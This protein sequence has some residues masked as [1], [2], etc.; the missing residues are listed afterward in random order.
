LKFAV[1]PPPKASPTYKA[2]SQVSLIDSQSLALQQ[3]LD[4]DLEQ[5]AALNRAKVRRQRLTVGVGGGL[6]AAAVAVTLLLVLPTGK[7]TNVCQIPRLS[8]LADCSTSHVGGIDVSD[9]FGE[10]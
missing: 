9:R 8:S 1:P 7:A 5:L 2:S 4:Q 10:P 3:Q 6:A